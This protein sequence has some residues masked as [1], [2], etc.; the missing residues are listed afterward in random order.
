M[1]NQ[2]GQY[3]LSP[4][5]LLGVSGGVGYSI[6][7]SSVF[8]C[9]LSAELEALLLLP[10]PFGISTRGLAFSCVLSDFFETSCF[11]FFCSLYLCFFVPSKA[12]AFAPTQ[13]QN[14]RKQS[15][16][17]RSLQERTQH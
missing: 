7:A 15:Q 3:S 1:A 13:S 6:S 11:S 9:V 5:L 10:L 14:Y 12:C 4:E 16:G 17:S 8:S 2:V